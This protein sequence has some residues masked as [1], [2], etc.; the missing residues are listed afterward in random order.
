MTPIALFGASNTYSNADRTVFSNRNPNSNAKKTK[1]DVLY[2]ESAQISH[3]LKYKVIST[4][5]AQTNK[6]SILYIIMTSNL[7]IISKR[8]VNNEFMCNN[9]TS[10]CGLGHKRPRSYCLRLDIHSMA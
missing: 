4:N 3:F 2:T 6:L 8:R 10:I 5:K 9:I 7:N 1:R